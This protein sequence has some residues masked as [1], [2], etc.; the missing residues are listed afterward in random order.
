M[1]SENVATKDSL[2]LVTPA[3]GAEIILGMQDL[4]DN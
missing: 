3:T 4:L 1:L 2:R